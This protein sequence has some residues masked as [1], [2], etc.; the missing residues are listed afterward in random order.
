[1]NRPT[2]DTMIDAIALSSPSGRMSKRA[3]K[4]AE[5]RLRVA[6]FGINGLPKPEHP[7]EDAAIRLR[8]S[9]ATL[10]DLAAR[11]MHPRKYI[12]E[13]I[14]LERQAD[15]VDT[16]KGETHAKMVR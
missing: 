5:E 10:R 4:A 11:G 7:P 8:R 9:A 13:A 1:M 14:R 6:L 3:R 15:E 2:S 16:R 12:R